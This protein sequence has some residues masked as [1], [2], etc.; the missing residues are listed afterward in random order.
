M[1]C[2]F[3]WQFTAGGNRRENIFPHPK[4]ISP[5]FTTTSIAENCC[6]VTI[7]TSESC[8]KNIYLESNPKAVIQ[9]AIVNFD[10]IVNVR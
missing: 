2:H 8:V 9:D 10:I 4:S 1:T 3:C 7:N 5:Y 6:N